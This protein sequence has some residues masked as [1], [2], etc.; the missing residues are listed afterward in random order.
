MSRWVGRPLNTLASDGGMNVP[1]P[2]SSRRVWRFGAHPEAGKQR[3]ARGPAPPCQGDAGLQRM[4]AF[5]W[6]RWAACLGPCEPLENSGPWAGL[7]S[8]GLLRKDRAGRLFTVFQILF[9]FPRPS[10]HLL[11]EDYLRVLCC[12]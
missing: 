12:D 11:S 8:S 2:P 4:V 10:P 9:S 3:C 7:E 1:G 6:L 5:P